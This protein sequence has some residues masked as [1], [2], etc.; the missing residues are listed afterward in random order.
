MVEGFVQSF[1]EWVKS[2][3][4]ITLSWLIGLSGF[5]FGLYSMASQ[6]RNDKE[7][8]QFKDVYKEIFEN[9]RLNLKGK[10]TEEQ[11]ADLSSQFEKL[12]EQVTKKIPEQARK[13]LLEDQKANLAKIIAVFYDQYYKVNETLSTSSSSSE[14]DPSLIAAIESSIM[15]SYTKEQDQQRKIQYLIKMIFIISSVS[16]L[17]PFVFESVQSGMIKTSSSAIKFIYRNFGQYFSSDGI[18]IYTIITL[19]CTSMVYFLFSKAITKFQ[20]SNP[21]IA[22]LS[23]LLLLI[24]WILSLFIVLS[25]EYELGSYFFPAIIVNILILST[26]LS[27]LIYS[28][29]YRK[30]VIDRIRAYRVK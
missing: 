8:K 19:I 1:I 11:V 17:F 18:I 26:A 29:R 24:V 25:L 20:K 4:G 30:L 3:I 6:R 15:P 10:Y 16:L 27:L 13:V 2:D 12:E 14:L 28:I 22:V 23:T 21:I 5:I 7:Q 9:A